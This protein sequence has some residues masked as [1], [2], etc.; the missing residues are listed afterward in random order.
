MCF[1]GL[2]Q[3][4]ELVRTS[5]FYKEAKEGKFVRY[6]HSDTKTLYDSFRRGAKESSKLISAKILKH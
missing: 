4:P 3:G 6:L 5:K 1:L 2:L